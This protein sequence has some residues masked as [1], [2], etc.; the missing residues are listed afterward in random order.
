MAA[1]AKDACQPGGER[2]GTEE[3]KIVENEHPT[4]GVGA[5]SHV[6]LHVGQDDVD[7]EAIGYLD[8]SNQAHTH[9]NCHSLE[10]REPRQALAYELA[11]L[12]LPSFTAAGNVAAEIAH[13]DPWPL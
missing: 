5:G 4:D 9:Q 3:A 8:G 13:Q 12:F 6:P 1:R 2:Y 10:V 7:G 11:V